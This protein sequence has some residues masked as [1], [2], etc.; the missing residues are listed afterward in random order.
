MS[1]SSEIN[2]F[3][4]DILFKSVENDEP[5]NFDVDGKIRVVA[6]NVFAGFI[7]NAFS[8][9]TSSAKSR[10]NSKE[11]LKALAKRS[12]SSVSNEDLFRIIKKLVANR[13]IPDI[14][15]GW[16]IVSDIRMK[17]IHHQIREKINTFI[18]KTEN[19]SLAKCLVSLERIHFATISE[20]YMKN[21]EP[22]FSKGG[23]SGVYFIK[24]PIT[25]E[26]IGVF[27][28]SD[29]EAYCEHNPKGNLLTEKMKKNDI[30]VLQDLR[31]GYSFKG[32]CKREIGSHAIAEALSY[33]FVPTVREV[34][35]P[36][37]Q[38]AT[39]SDEIVMK[40]G[41]LQ[42]F[43]KGVTLDDDRQALTKVN[44]KH[45]QEAALFD[46]LT[47]NSDR[48]YENILV[49]P[50]T[51]KLHLIDQGRCLGVHMYGEPTQRYHK[52]LLA[53]E[54]VSLPA[55]KVPTNPDVIRAFVKM[56]TKE[57]ERKL[58][59]LGLSDMEIKPMLTRHKVMCYALKKGYTIHEMA[60]LIK[61]KSPK[62]M[63]TVMTQQKGR[64]DSKTFQRSLAKLFFTAIDKEMNIKHLQKRRSDKTYE[65]EK[66]SRLI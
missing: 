58:L 8:K 31:S 45:L 65:K 25:F 4:A 53:S 38:S 33:D 26:Y 61:R 5:I 20:K 23:S 28:P 2:Q 48:T 18:T 63:K 55:C 57:V 56:N 34:K 51:G 40:S 37:R 36:F 43:I 14:G 19:L 13:L 27:K 21:L 17:T 60:M 42:V 22:H 1:G 47:D 7:E 16:K 29:E 52:S 11:A 3:N 24:D 15:S 66:N 41:S 35:V 54:L 12:S 30:D 62:F 46:I 6:S 9:N 50:S 49:D 10:K 39:G 44:K 32:D 64:F 59:E